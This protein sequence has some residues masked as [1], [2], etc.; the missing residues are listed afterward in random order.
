ML[1][2][3]NQNDNTAPQ[4][5]LF[6]IQE[7][8]FTDDLSDDETIQQYIL[9]YTRYVNLVRTGQIVTTEE[10]DETIRRG[11]KRVNEILT[12]YGF[13]PIYSDF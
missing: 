10:S 3:M 12:E 6:P 13:K 1:C 7:R 8:E 11:L 2:R 5:L 4:L 9:R